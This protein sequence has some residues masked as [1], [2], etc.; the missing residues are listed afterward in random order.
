MTVSMVSIKVIVIGQLSHYF[1]Q[2]LCTAEEKWKD[3]YH[4][5]KVALETTAG[6]YKP[7]PHSV[8]P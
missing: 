3:F 5:E 2:K 8:F 6:D 4:V 1:I 7:V